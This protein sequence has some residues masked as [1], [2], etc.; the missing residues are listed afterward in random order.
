MV[1]LSAGSAAE[2]GHRPS[3]RPTPQKNLSSQRNRGTVREASAERVGSGGL[4][5][6]IPPA[7]ARGRNMEVRGGLYR[8]GVPR[9]MD[10][11]PR[12]LVR[13]RS[14]ISSENETEGPHERRVLKG[15]SHQP[16]AGVRPNG[17]DPSGHPQSGEDSDWPSPGGGRDA[18]NGAGA[19]GPNGIGERRHRGRKRRNPTVTA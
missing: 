7:G 3:F 2:E 11:A 19:A 15:V 16:H 6:P 10:A 5:H 12:S 17:L 8:L 18:P 1:A 14:R 13:R 9:A 4:R